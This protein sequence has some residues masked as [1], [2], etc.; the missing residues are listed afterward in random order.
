MQR[1]RKRG[2]RSR[3]YSCK[4]VTWETEVQQ[5]LHLWTHL[6]APG[7]K[8]DT[9]HNQQYQ[10]FLHLSRK[11]IDRPSSRS[12][13]KHIE[14]V[15]KLKTGW[16][17]LLYNERPKVIILQGPNGCGK[18]LVAHALRLWYYELWFYRK[19][20]KYG[21]T[22]ICS[23]TNSTPYSMLNTLMEEVRLFMTMSHQQ[24]IVDSPYLNQG[25]LYNLVKLVW[26]HQFEVILV[27]F[28]PDQKVEWN[29]MAKELMNKTF[30][31]TTFTEVLQQC[32]EISSSKY[33]KLVNSW[34]VPIAQYKYKVLDEQ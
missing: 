12:K 5:H 4:R 24:I 9:K 23:S 32:M 25:E 3:N 18:T 14:K 20:G 33:D 30:R 1:P 6:I 34:P 19:S 31:T 2:Y 27:K 15:Y 29:M 21:I 28:E 8:I 22:P 10:K 17:Q 7:L 13:L 11:L 26:S 16:D